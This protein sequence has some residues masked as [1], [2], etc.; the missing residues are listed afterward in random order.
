LKKTTKFEWSNKCEEAFQELK[1]QLTTTSIL[2]LP[3][4]R[5]EYTI[6]SDASKNRLGCIL[7]QDDKVRAY[8]FRQLK[9]H[10]KNC[11][12]YDLKSAA[13]VFALKI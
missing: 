2:T 9:P 5:K 1:R 12:T 6:Y 3:V 7:M 10:E 4:E 13:V 8:A 11:P